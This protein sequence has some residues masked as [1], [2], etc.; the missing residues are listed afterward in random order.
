MNITN[1]NLKKMACI[2]DE[3]TVLERT[4]CPCCGAVHY[5]LTDAYEYF[6]YLENGPVVGPY[7]GWDDAL[8]VLCDACRYLT[9]KTF[10]A[11]FLDRLDREGEIE[12]AA[13]LAKGCLDV[14]FHRKNYSEGQECQS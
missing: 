5:A 4:L 8:D 6:D 14:E 1:E 7:D 13:E 2:I 3:D 12:F 11:E 10:G 9:K